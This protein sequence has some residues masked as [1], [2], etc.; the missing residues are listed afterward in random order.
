M[1]HKSKQARFCVVNKLS[2]ML[3]VDSLFRCNLVPRV[4][5]LP[6]PWNERGRDPGLVWSRVFQIFAPGGGKIRDP[7]NEVD[8]DEGQLV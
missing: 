1:K 6:A 3:N 2:Q 7:G 8:F 5:H 4:S